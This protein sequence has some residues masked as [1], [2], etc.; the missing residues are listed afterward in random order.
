MTIHSVKIGQVSIVPEVRI[1]ITELGHVVRRMSNVKPHGLRS[2]PTNQF[3][4]PDEG[5]VRERRE[6]RPDKRLRVRPYPLSDRPRC[7]L[8]F[9]PTPDSISAMTRER[10]PM[11]LSEGVHGEEV[12]RG[13][14]HDVARIGRF[15]R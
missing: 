1:S 10:Q 6:S 11:A 15:F 3:D 5:L 7:F 14:V 12:D 9:E 2:V 4:G 13:I 8:V